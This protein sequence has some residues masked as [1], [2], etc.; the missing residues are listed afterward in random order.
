MVGLVHR[1][2]HINLP[3]QNQ[4][5]WNLNFKKLAIQMLPEGEFLVKKFGFG[6]EL[7]G[8]LVQ[9][10]L[11]SCRYLK[12]KLPPNSLPFWLKIHPQCSNGG[13]S[14]RW[15]GIQID[16]HCFFVGS[17]LIL[18]LFSDWRIR[19]RSAEAQIRGRF[20][21]RKQRPLHFNPKTKNLNSQILHFNPKT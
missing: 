2:K 14:D 5:I 7:G 3:F 18:W 11:Q 10:W 4:T 17:S 19:Q 16:A 15:V 13:Y 12:P 8:S 20:H 1:T 21:S 6:R 9:G